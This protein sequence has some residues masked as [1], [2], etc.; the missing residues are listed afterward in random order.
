M[1][2]DCK[3]HGLSG[4]CTLRTCWKKMPT[5][6]E[7]G[8]RLKEKFDGASKVIPSNDGKNFIPYG[9]TIKP[10]NRGDLVYSQ[11]S[12][13]YCKFNRKS[14]SLGTVGRICNVTSPGVDGCELLC[15]G[16]GFDTKLIREKVNCDCRFRWCCEVT[17]NTCNQKR[18]I[19]TC[20]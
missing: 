11:D 18:T 9:T 4:S 19:H 1:H 5:F 6:R 7:V 17:C 12:P 2:T 15:C 8:N 14:G 3:C 20:H 13:D 16:R 10:P